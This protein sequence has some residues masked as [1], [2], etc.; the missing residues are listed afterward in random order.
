MLTK[1]EAWNNVV[2]VLHHISFPP[3]LD[4]KTCP[5]NTTQKNYIMGYLEICPN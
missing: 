4:A 1:E 3:T 5:V 2:D